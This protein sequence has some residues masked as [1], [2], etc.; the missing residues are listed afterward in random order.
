M[1]EGGKLNQN[2]FKSMNINN[3]A[4][5]MELLEQRFKAQAQAKAAESAT[6]E[7][8][9]PVEEAKPSKN[10]KKKAKK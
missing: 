6:Q 3:K 4:G 9:A 10:K 5:F 7:T 2:F 8:T 1:K